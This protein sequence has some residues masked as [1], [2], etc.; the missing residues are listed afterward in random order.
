MHPTTTTM[1]WQAY[2][3]VKHYAI[4]AKLRVQYFYETHAPSIL[5][6][7]FSGAHAAPV[8]RKRLIR[9]KPVSKQ[10]ISQKEA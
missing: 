7:L 10:V 4:Q 9:M 5:L 6:W 3:Y 2:A 1:I 8:K